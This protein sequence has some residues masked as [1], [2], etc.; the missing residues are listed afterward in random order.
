MTSTEFSKR[1][2]ALGSAAQDEALV[3]A[4]KDLEGS[5]S[6]HALKEILKRLSMTALN[7]AMEPTMDAEQRAFASGILRAITEIWSAVKFAEDVD[8]LSYLEAPK[9]AS[10]V[11]A[12]QEMVVPEEPVI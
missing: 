12:L 4:L 9:T 7:I 8:L 11:Q 3:I 2:R 1:L 5:S 10:K 6:G